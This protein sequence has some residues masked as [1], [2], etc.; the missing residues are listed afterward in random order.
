MEVAA[1][2]LNIKNIIEII[3]KTTK[4]NTNFLADVYLLKD[5]SIVYKW[6]NRKV[7]PRNEDIERIVSFAQKESSD[8]QRRI[9]RERIEHLIANSSL[10]EDMKEFL[11]SKEEFSDFL[12]EA[13]NVTTSCSS[14]IEVSANRDAGKSVDYGQ[15]NSSSLNIDGIE[16][17]YTGHIKLDMVLRKKGDDA[18]DEINNNEIILKNKRS[19]A[20]SLI[21]KVGRG[22]KKITFMST[23][24]IVVVL[25]IFIFQLLKQI[26]APEI[27]SHRN[28]KSSNE[29]QLTNEVTILKSSGVKDN[30]EPISGDKDVLNDIKTGSEGLVKKLPEKSK[31]PEEQQ[32]SSPKPVKSHTKIQ[33]SNKINDTKK[34]NITYYNEVNNNYINNNYIN[35]TINNTTI[36]VSE[37]ANNNLNKNIKIW[38]DK[39]CGLLKNNMTDTFDDNRIDSGL[40]TRLD[41]SINWEENHQQM[42]IVEDLN[43]KLSSKLISNYFAKDY[44]LICTLKPQE[45]DLHSGIGFLLNVQAINTGYYSPN[46]FNGYTLVINKFKENPESER[47]DNYIKFQRY[48]YSAGIAEECVLLG[49]KRLD[50]QI[51]D[52]YE[53][54]LKVRKINNTFS[55]Y[56]ND[57][58]NPLFEIEDSVYTQGRVG[59]YAYRAGGS[60]D[61]FSLKP[62]E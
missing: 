11:F 15:N 41:G 43:Q 20:G 16:G 57:M 10:N 47:Y 61:N 37:K 2:N 28:I 17:E 54:H 38:D 46:N 32:L 48:D 6:K 22:Y 25:N 62:I 56:V 40:W 21:A 13:L 35:N 50:R 44:E 49:Q 12:M 24:V 42:N 27:E 31:L 53:F 52:D 39:N 5:A 59:L 1:I 30:E 45:L 33:S 58:E 29:S 51:A 26:N 36:R 18:S 3:L 19:E 8:A 9:I 60:F 7:I 14:G 23:V 34:V 55:V 4:K